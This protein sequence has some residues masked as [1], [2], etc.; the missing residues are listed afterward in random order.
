MAAS[1]S[2]PA[3][4]SLH[5]A[6]NL[7][8]LLWVKVVCS[9]RA[10]PS[11]E[12][13]AAPQS[14]RHCVVSALGVP[15]A[16]ALVVKGGVCSAPACDPP[17]G[18]P[19]RLVS[20]LAISEDLLE[21]PSLL[22]DFLCAPAGAPMMVCLALPAATVGTPRPPTGEFAPLGDVRSGAGDS[23]TAR[24]AWRAP[25]AA[26]AVAAAESGPPPVTFAPLIGPWRRD[27]T[28]EAASSRAAAPPIASDTAFRPPATEFAPLEGPWNGARCFG[29]A[30]P[31]LPL[32]PASGCAVDFRSLS[33]EF[34]PLAG[35]RRDSR[36]LSAARLLAES[37]PTACDALAEAR[38]VAGRLSVLSEGC[39]VPFG[40][41]QASTSL[42]VQTAAPRRWGSSQ[43][44]V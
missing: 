27:R 29:A 10:A 14:S 28:P 23:V 35:L 8:T 13:P 37:P 15:A 39:G 20:R 43:I 12:P 1:I 42:T 25:L 31:V 17:E 11:I 24:S 32:L 41:L 18:L 44:P 19:P 3:S 22:G 21:R 4:K 7:H 33:A 6:E 30:Q 38:P 5:L 9:V 40:G 2:W 34:A 26:T 36:S 16:K